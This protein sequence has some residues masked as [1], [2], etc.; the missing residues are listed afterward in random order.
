MGPIILPRT[1]LGFFPTPIVKLKRLSEK[2]KGPDL[3]VKRDDMTG[4]AF[5]GNK[6]RKLEFLLADAS[7]KKCD[8]IITGGAE[9]SNHCRQT[10]A[11]A[12]MCG[13]ECHLVL[14]GEEPELP[15]G[16][17]LLDKLFNVKIHW[18]GELRKGEKIPEIAEQLMVAGRKPYIVPYGGSNKIGATGFVE[19]IGELTE[20]NSLLKEN[21]THI[22]FASSSGGTHAGMIVGKSIYNLGS[23]LI[24][25]E[26]D[27]NRD[28][29]TP[30]SK[31]VLDLANTTAGFLKV[32]KTFKNDDVTLMNKYLGGGYGVVGN[33]ERRAI[34][35][36][37]ETEGV[38]V[39]PVYTG[40][41][42]GAL[43]NLIEEKYFTKDDKVLFWHTGGTPSLFPYAGD[44]V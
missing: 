27:K 33:L 15:T 35:L 3:F 7:V 26:I 13:L 29:E 36:L 18:T 4:L 42:F 32:T 11:A 28:D 44:L 8:T 43:V 24:G 30:Y 16:N 25:I 5:G 17:L 38:L 12:A 1:K 23:C 34:K 21:F 37:A 19:A 40:R 9:Q 2:L 6:T 14:G 10:A 39:D 31:R 41:A 20:Q 22:V